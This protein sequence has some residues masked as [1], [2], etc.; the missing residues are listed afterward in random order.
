MAEL[1]LDLTIDISEVET[2]IEKLKSV[3]T[4]D[5]FHRAM[6]GIFKREGSHIKTILGKDIPLQYKV[7]STEVRETVGTPTVTTSEGTTGC[8]IPVKGKRRGVGTKYSAKGALHG[9]ETL[10]R[11]HYDITAKILTERESKLPFDI[12]G[13]APFRNMPSKLNKQAFYRTSRERF[14]I[15]PVMGIAIP[16]MPIN[17]SEEDVQSDI[18]EHLKGRIEARFQA[19]IKNGR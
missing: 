16:Q 11:G 5:Q 7:K 10:R 15:K 14:P 18:V 17:R 8:I 13:K 12:K 3:M 1:G 19:L 6:Y 4:P 9:W 2:E